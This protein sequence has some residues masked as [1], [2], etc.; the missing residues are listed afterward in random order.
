VRNDVEPRHPGDHV[1]AGFVDGTL[2][3]GE[4][5]AVAEH[6]RGC[7]E[8][9]LL[10]T[11][12]A[13]FSREEEALPFAGHQRKKKGLAP[14]WMA[15]AAVLAAIAVT[16][17][18]LRWNERRTSPIARLIA[19]APRDHRQVEPR[20]SGFR[21]APLQAPSRGEQIADPADLKLAGAAGQVLE[22][23]LTRPDADAQ[24][25][26][27]VAYLLIGRHRE[28]VAALERSAMASNEPA[29]WNDLAAARYASASR[30]GPAQLQQALEDVGRALQADPR[31]A[32][33]LFNRALILERM[34]SREQARA[35]WARYLE[36][37]PSGEWSL[38]ARA[39][40]GRP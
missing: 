7:A 9:R 24:R 16:A 10:V 11:E 26:T 27:G 32:E 3:A 5:P 29:A 2:T 33:A 13:R 20:L 17:P 36:A 6:L 14:V 8:C 18:L 39:R 1:L 37:E 19:V 38:E 34:E 35:A 40:L 4:I 23:T 30:G 25:A 31:L 22:Q 28:S 15:V 21:W 12:T